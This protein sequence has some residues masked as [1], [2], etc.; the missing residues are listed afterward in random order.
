MD[1]LQRT[2][3]FRLLLPFIF[4]IILYQYVE[5]FHWSLFALFV[6]SICL[7]L[8]SFLIHTPK[9]QYQFRWLFGCGIFL[10]MLTL[11][12]FQSD[13]RDKENVFD[14]LY[15][16]GIYRVEL[17]AAPIEKAKSYLCK[18]DVIQYFD[19]NS[20]TPTRGKAIL[21]LQKDSAASDLLFGD[22]LLVE[23]EFT[24]P[25]KAQNPDGFDYAAYLK[26]QGVGATCYI[27]SGSWQMTGR[28]AT[29][30]IRREADKCQNYLLNV[31][32]KFKIEGDEFAVLAAL[33]LG[34]TDDLQPDLRASYS[35]TGAMH[36]LSVSGMHVGVVYVVMAFLLSFLNKN[37]RQKILK[38]IFITLFLWAYAFLTG[39]SPAVVRATLMFSFVAI[40]TCFERKS[41]IYN[42]IFM[43][44]FFML[45]INPNFL[46]D[47]GFQLSYS[48]VLS[49]IFF[50]P[51]INKLYTPNNKLT[52]LTWEMFSVSIAAQ[53]GTTPFTLY[54]FQ[55]F[56]NY[57]LITN[58]VAIPLSSLII[59]LAMGLLMVS[60]VPYLSLAI[61]FLLKWSLWGLNFVIVSIQNLPYSIS[62][63]SLDV[64]QTLVLFLAI[65]CISGYY[66][67]KKFAPLIVAL[68]SIL[69]TC[70]FNLQVNYQTLTSKR[71]IVYAG[72]KN[73]HVNF[74]NRN[75]NYVFS[76]DSVEAMRIAKPFW[77]NQKLENPH[78]LHE[79]NWFSNGFAYFEG[80]R[81]LILTQ[82][83]L[84]KKTTS[85]PLEIDYLII[86]KGLKPKIE[87]ILECVQP[88]KIIVDKNIS[89]WYTESIKQACKLRKIGFYSVAEQGAYILNFI[90]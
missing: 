73:T 15:Q 17:T 76:T 65:F 28:N 35:A 44:A 31:Y 71:M 87:Q 13:E 3:F 60:F 66:F 48:A 19:S 1:F 37:Q 26:R 33:T 8:L 32:R 70:L 24:A 80:S 34:Y 52:H 82:D 88:H 4:G 68:F 16:K 90:D 61:A 47:V 51:I 83:F 49:I 50:Q 78:Y 54:Y 72:Q 6:L 56:P 27:S 21:Y 20:W 23:A 57:F 59:Y 25:E 84:I 79:N 38:T 5:L 55:Q 41:Q 42:T 40:A 58:I 9:R 81:I 69:L 53:L 30:S 7:I 12:Y 64:R 46:Y 22:R 75:Q 2:P 11:A 62:H 36:I 43:S 85:T 63:I 45:I 18:V 14:H 77:Q 29:F 39:L 67:S 89:K 86:G 74:I 10:F